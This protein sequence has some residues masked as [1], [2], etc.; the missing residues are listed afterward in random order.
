[1]SF[2]GAIWLALIGLSGDTRVAV[3]SDH[4]LN[5]KYFAL[6]ALSPT[7]SGGC[8]Y[9]GG[10]NAALRVRGNRSF[11]ISHVFNG[12]LPIGVRLALYSMAAE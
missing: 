12:D 3:A 11:T 8:S 9:R 6:H 4:L 5:T 7:H 2:A 1:M 10:I